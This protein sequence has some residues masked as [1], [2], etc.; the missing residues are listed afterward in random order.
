MRRLIFVC[1]CTL[2]VINAFASDLRL[3]YKQ[4]AS[5]WMNE[6]LP[7]GN[8]FMGAMIYG[9]VVR[10]EVQISEESIWAGGPTATGSYNYG[11]Q[12]GSWQ[13][14]PAVRE[15][16][17]EGK[18]KEAEKLAQRHFTGKINPATDS[19]EFGDYGAQQP[20]GSL[21]ITP[22]I[23]D[24]LCVGYVREL[25]LQS[26]VA[27]V[28]YTRV[29]IAFSHEY[30]ASYPERLIIARYENNS[31]H[32]IDYQV[33]FESPHRGLRE[34][35]KGNLLKIQGAHTG[36]GLLIAG[37][38]LFKTDG[39]LQKHKEGYII[40]KA[41]KIEI[42]IS[43]AT[44]YK[45]EYPHYR[46]GDYGAVN[47]KA[48]GS[49]TSS[50]YEQI[51]SD[52]IRDYQSLFNRVSFSLCDSSGQADDIPTDERLYRYSK[53]AYDPGF[54]SLYFQYGRYLL[55]SSSR[56]GSMPAHLQGKWNNSMSP[57]WACDY[58]MNIN[59]QMIYW[60]AEVTNLS[61]CH[62][63]LLAYIHALRQPGRI[64]AKEYFNARGWCVHTMNNA[65]GF[66]A[67]GWN[68]N[69]GYA[70]NSAAWL[71]Q[72]V[73][74]HF[75]YTDDQTY[76][77]EFAYP[78]MKEVG[79]FWLDYLTED[80]D[81][82]LVSSPSYSPEHGVVSA[83]ATIDQEI[84]YDLFTNLLEARPYLSGEDLFLD[85]IAAARRRL[86]PLQIGKYGQLQE[87]KDDLDN[88]ANQHRHVSH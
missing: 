57:P 33:S 9:G 56:P 27:S 52:H 48:I 14:L 19:G 30:M 45:N 69:W 8:G 71:C 86:V 82:L 32:G 18:I 68:F 40:R 87:W 36:N 22:L 13:H 61:E 76:L 37:E 1:I 65:Y 59:L 47:H 73:W 16:L 70:P 54:E 88:P 64:T 31:E 7:I 29:G 26:A 53:G 44:N 2:A 77:K 6:G 62:Q 12:Q 4:P 58:H 20:F 21:F 23:E 63:P 15:L 11:N 85:S 83:G 46:G 43:V 10:D 42:Y 5:N 55:I 38:I 80:Q 66:T 51:K 17:A 78:L 72:H 35:L 79:E 41:R 39:R 24:T 67:P 75:L 3:F 25:D 28:S 74:S 34:K 49:A 81:H 60:P 50:S 84:A